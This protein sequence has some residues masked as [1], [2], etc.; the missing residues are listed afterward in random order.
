MKDDAEGIAEI[1]VTID[2]PDE[3]F[4]S[5]DEKVQFETVDGTVTITKFTVGDANGDG[6]VNARDV[7]LMQRYLSGWSFEIVGNADANGDGKVNARDVVLLQRYLSGWDVI[8]G[9]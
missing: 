1:S 7:V 2:D 9:G 8:L 5:K 4:N 6:K 3:L